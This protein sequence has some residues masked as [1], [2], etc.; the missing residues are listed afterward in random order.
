MRVSCST[1]PTRSTCP[2]IS[3]RRAIASKARS[4]RFRPAAA[5][6][7]KWI[8]SDSLYPQGHHGHNVHFLIH[9]L[10]LGGRYDDS[11][12][13]TQHLLT[14]KENPRERSGNNQ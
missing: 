13:W 5:V 2:G 8:E 6:E 12:K 9:A 4:R 7:L 10:N 1:S 14:F 11:M 3:T